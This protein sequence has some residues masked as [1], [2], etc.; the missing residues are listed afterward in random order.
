MTAERSRGR[1]RRRLGVAV[2]LEGR[3][4]A[5]V[6]GLRRAVGDPSLGRIAPHVTLVPPV[7]VAAD[8]LP[9]ALRV[10][11]DAARDVR[12]MRLSLGAPATFLPYNPVLFLSVGG[13]LERLQ[14]LRDAVFRPPLE[15]PLTWPWVPHVTLADGADR[16]LIEAATAVLGAYTAVVEVSRVVLL[17]ESPGRRWTPVADAALGRRARVGTGGLEIELTHSRM[18]DPEAAV[19]LGA[20]LARLGDPRTAL[21]E[22]ALPQTALPEAGPPEAGP[23][24]TGRPG[25]ERVWPEPIVVTARR[26]GQPVGAAIAWFDPSGAHVAVVVAG[27]HQGQGIGS[28]LLAQVETEAR[29]AGWQ[30]PVI[31]AVG[32]PDF[33]RAR[34]GWARPAGNPA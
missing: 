32:P 21:P 24:E 2:V 31:D 1:R 33:Y 4:G 7:N 17:E 18:V 16:A 9:A 11:R 15:R 20:E 10:L 8:D 19:V 13:D 14:K 12:P 34:S 30:V 23:L 5:E 28:C 22:T 26:E 3:V 29:S 27:P 25:T 6:D